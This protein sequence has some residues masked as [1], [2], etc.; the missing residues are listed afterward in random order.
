[1]T[2]R[3]HCKPEKTEW[4]RKLRQCPT[5]SEK[6]LF[7]LLKPRPWGLK[8]RFQSVI[9]GWIVDFYCASQKLVIEVDGEYHTDPL[10]Q[11][12]DAWRDSVMIK[13]G[14]HILR[15]SA[16]RVMQNP[17]DALDDIRKQIFHGFPAIPKRTG[18]KHSCSRRK[19]RERDAGDLNP[20]GVTQVKDDPY[21]R[22]V[23]ARRGSMSKPLKP[24][25]PAGHLEG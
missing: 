10:Q 12:A 5:P 25:I 4:A 2:F 7:D 21:T 1:M 6:V 13:H 18:R 23:Y 8:F 22:E 3:K 17:N 20:Q 19:K 15:I 24:S 9:L 14:F 16:S 11:R